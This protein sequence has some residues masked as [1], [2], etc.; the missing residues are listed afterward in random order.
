MS[1]DLFDRPDPSELSA[2]QFGPLNAVIPQDWPEVWRDFA[3]SQYITL[4]SAPGVGPAHTEALARLSVALTLGI[5][6]D[7]GGTQPYI[8]VG[9]LVAASSKARR[10]LELLEQR[11][12][13]RDVSAATGLTV[14]RV[15]RIQA[16]WRRDQW[17]SR[18]TTLPLD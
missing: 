3:T 8:P 7:L 15:R 16:T 2:A 17:R 18:Q 1:A 11:M 13:Y 12:S 9:T 5:A 14:S 4:I 6:T 10:V